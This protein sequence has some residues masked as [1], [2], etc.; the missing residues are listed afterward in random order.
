MKPLLQFIPGIFILLFYIILNFTHSFFLNNWILAIVIIILIYSFLQHLYV[1]IDLIMSKYVIIFTFF[2]FFSSWIMDTI[3]MAFSEA[4]TPPLYAIFSGVLGY[5]LAFSVLYIGA[6]EIY[7]IRSKAYEGNAR[8]TQSYYVLPFALIITSYFMLNAYFLVF[9][10]F[11]PLIVYLIILTLLSVKFKHIKDIRIFKYVPMLIYTVF[12]LLSFVMLFIRDSRPIL[13]F[14][15]IRN[16]HS[17]VV[18]FLIV[19]IYI[20]GM[21]G[22]LLFLILQEVR[23]VK[24]VI[25]PITKTEKPIKK[26]SK[27]EVI[28]DI[29]KGL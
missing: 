11:W 13:A 15:F 17:L 20:I 18:Y 2:L 8:S 7:Y 14:E 22:L 1:T 27:E 9:N 25:K 10:M 16:A 26:F 24:P 28:K 21:M 19:G 29:K 5:L 6:L 23:F 3:L 4:I 12:M